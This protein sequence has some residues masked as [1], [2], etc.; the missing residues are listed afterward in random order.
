MARQSRPS[1]PQQRVQRWLERGRAEDL[2]RLVINTFGGSLD[3]Q[4][5]ALARSRQALLIT[6][7]IIHEGIEQ[8]LEDVWMAPPSSIAR[9]RA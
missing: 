3:G 5:K 4:L 7:G 1:A 6:S 2:G 9:I 8:D